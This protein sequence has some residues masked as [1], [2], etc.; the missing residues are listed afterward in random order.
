MRKNNKGITLIALVIT[1]I[2]LLILAGVTI[3][4]LTGENGILTRANEAKKET[5]KAKAKEQIQIAVMGS[6]GVNGDIDKEKLKENLRSIK[7]LKYKGEMLSSETSISSLPIVVELDNISFSINKNGEITGANT[8][9]DYGLKVGDYV[10]YNEGTGYKYFSNDEYGTGVDWGDNYHMAQGT[11]DIEDMNW[12]V[13]GVNSDGNIELISDRPTSSMLY[14]AR[15]VGY[16]NLEK[17]L[18]DFCD[19]LYG[20]G[21]FALESRSLNIDDCDKLSGMPSDEE[22]KEFYN[23]YGHLYQFKYSNSSGR[24]QSR[25]S[26]DEGESWTDW[27][28]TPLATFNYPEEGCVWPRWI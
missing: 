17:N 18:N 15:W 28:D 11:I 9:E 3:A 6:Y 8:L 19:T 22:K 20:N 7:G 14:I 25:K 24:V 5:G 27:E 21:N 16:V 13:L 2:V 12:R 1:I 4:T 10:A 23:S 26:V